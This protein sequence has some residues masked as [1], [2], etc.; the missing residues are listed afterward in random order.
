M[1]AL[2]GASGFA[3]FNLWSSLIA[4]IGSIILLTGK[5]A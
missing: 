1:D 3:G 5:C 2:V 4:L